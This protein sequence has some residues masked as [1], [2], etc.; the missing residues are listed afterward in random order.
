MTGWALLFLGI[1]GLSCHKTIPKEKYLVDEELGHQVKL[2]HVVNIPFALAWLPVTS[3]YTARFTLIFSAMPKDC[4][5][6]DLIAQV[7]MPK[8]IETSKILWQNFND[9]Q[10]I[11][12]L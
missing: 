11:A 2:L 9:Q 1:Q 5:V 7:Q 4:K 8:N 3:G 6:F 10:W 12:Y